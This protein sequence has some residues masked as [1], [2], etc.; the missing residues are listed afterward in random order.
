[1]WIIRNFYPLFNKNLN[2]DNIDNIHSH[3]PTHF[4][5]SLQIASREIKENEGGD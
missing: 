3:G 5:S 2:H 1:M 4:V